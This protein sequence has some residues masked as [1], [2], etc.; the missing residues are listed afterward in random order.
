MGINK[1]FHPLPLKRRGFHGLK[2]KF[3]KNC[4]V[5]KVDGT[6]EHGHFPE[7]I[8]PTQPFL[9]MRGISYVRFLSP[10]N[11]ELACTDPEAYRAQIGELVKPELEFIHLE[12]EP[13]SLA[14]IGTKV[15]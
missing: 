8:S 11:V 7:A 14:H 4:I 5:E 13:Y 6:I 9:N 3:C 1:A 12:L 15:G 10:N 2:P